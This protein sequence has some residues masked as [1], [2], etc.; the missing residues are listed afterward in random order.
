MKNRLFITVIVVFFA[1]SSTRSWSIENPAI[2]NPAGSS[3]VPPSSLQS[4][5]IS[6]PNPI[7]T[8]GNLV[9]TGNVSRG[10]HFR[11][12]VPYGST[13]S[14]RAGLGSSS[15]SSFLRDSASNEYIGNYTNGYSIQPYYL[16]SQTVTTTRPGYSGVFRPIDTRI[17]DSAL[18]VQYPTGM[19]TTNGQET[20]TYPDWDTFTQAGTPQESSES[21]LP[22]LQ[23]QY[24]TETRP[25]QIVKSIRE[26]QLLTQDEAGKSKQDQQLMFERYQEQTQDTRLKTQEPLL[27]TQDQTLKTQEPLL[28]TQDQRLKTEDPGTALEQRFEVWSPE[29]KER[30]AA[31]IVQTNEPD[32]G[33]D[34]LT[35]AQADAVVKGPA[36]QDGSTLQK[37]TGWEPQADEGKPDEHGRDL[38]DKRNRLGSDVLE[39]IGQQLDDLTRS[40]DARLRTAPEEALKDGSTKTDTVISPQ[41]TTIDWGKIVHFYET[42]K[43]QYGQAADSQEEANL[44]FLE[45][46]KPESYREKNS[47]LDELNKL[48]QAELSA[49]AKSIRGPHTRPETFSEAKFNQHMQAAE[50]YLKAGRFYAAADSFALAS[51]YKLDPGEAGSDPVQAGGLALCF[52]GRG[53]ALLAAGEYIS[54]ALFLSRALEIAPEY[55]RTKIDLAGMLGGENKLESRIAEIKEWMGRNGSP[56]LEFLLG[57]VYYRMGRLGPAKQAIDATYTKMP[58]SPAVVAVKKAIDD[59]IAGQ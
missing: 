2:L 9:I 39:Q 5:L 40:I 45:T 22:G 25:L 34:A 50:D 37:V 30:Q 44:E 14:F 53:H 26:L 49:K 33:G 11:G 47:P 32:F 24:G 42:E 46:P 23:T 38:Q 35:L 54:S 29:H 16:Q 41:A 21:G 7:D 18:Q 20:Q 12:T 8:S 27:K 28:K 58:Q 43:D 4:G 17:N 3:T 15:L 56:K 36:F 1:L 48:S 57:Y 59:A 19:K 6:N 52:A 55:V 51:I 10:M 13:T 31:K